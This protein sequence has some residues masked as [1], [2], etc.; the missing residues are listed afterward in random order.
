MASDGS[1]DNNAVQPNGEAQERKKQIS[2]LLGDSTLRDLLIQKLTEGGHVARQNAPNQQKDTNMPGVNLFGSGGWP[3]FPAQLP[4]LPFHPQLAWGLPHNP[5]MAALVGSNQLPHGSALGSGQPGSSHE[6]G[7]E[8]KDYV[9]LLEEE[10]AS[11]LVQF[12]PA[13]DEEDTWNACETINSFI[14]EYL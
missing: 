4:F 1:Q 12:E 9:D 8:E 3:S 5:P 11:E 7:Q 2:A 14:K 6:Q 10:E 13:I